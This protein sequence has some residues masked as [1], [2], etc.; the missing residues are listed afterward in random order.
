[1]PHTMPMG[2][3]PRMR[4]ALPSCGFACEVAGIIPAYAGSTTCPNRRCSIPWDHPRV[5]GEHDI[6]TLDSGIREGSSP[7]MRGA[8]AHLCTSN[9]IARIIPAY[10]GSTSV[11]LIALSP[12]RDH[13]RVCGEHNNISGGT[14]CVRGSSPRM[15]GAHACGTAYTS[16]QVDHPR[17]CGEHHPW[18]YEYTRRSGSSPRM[19]GARRP[20]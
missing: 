14:E 6:F 19:R 15:R 13:P 7:R 9:A 3:S 12:S 8:L 4:G 1:M 11:S 20:S 18:R 17:V 5:C 2:S 10:A 16:E